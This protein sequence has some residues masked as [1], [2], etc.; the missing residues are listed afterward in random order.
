MNRFAIVEHLSSKIKYTEGQREL[1]ESIEASIEEL[2]RAREY[3][4]MVSDPQLID[5]AIHLEDAAKAK[6]TYLL[7]KAKENGITIENK[8]L[9]NDSDAV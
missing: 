6:F 8:F 5:Y 3:F 1:I 2:Q 9:Q 4:D 7:N